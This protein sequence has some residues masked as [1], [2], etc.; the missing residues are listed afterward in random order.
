MAMNT[1]ELRVELSYGSPGRLA[2]SRAAYL[3]RTS[4]SIPPRRPRNVEVHRADSESKLAVQEL[5]IRHL[6][7]ADPLGIQTS[8]GRRRRPRTLVLKRVCQHRSGS[9]AQDP[10]DSPAD[11]HRA[12]HEYVRRGNSPL[13]RRARLRPHRGERR[14]RGPFRGGDARRARHQPPQLRQCD[15]DHERGGRFALLP[16]GRYTRPSGSR[17]RVIRGLSTGNVSIVRA[18][19]REPRRRQSYRRE[20]RGR[21]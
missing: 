6:A 10:R 20:R 17:A 8:A 16:D 4:P 21:P 15:R 11:H 13:W 1:A 18:A 14:D 9:A 12:G 3:L 19:A 7:R 5:R 2:P